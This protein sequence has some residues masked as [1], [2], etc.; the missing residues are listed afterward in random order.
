[1][2][3]LHASG[4]PPSAV[5]P[6]GF[7]LDALLAPIPGDLPAGRDLRRDVSGVS[8][9]A[10]LRDA[11][12]EARAAEREAD[13]LDPGAVTPLPSWR[14]I[15]R[16]AIEGLAGHSKDLEFAAALTEA[17]VRLQGLPGLA[18]GATL[19]RGLCEGFWDA[20]HPMPDE[21]GMATRF[22]PVSGL[23]GADRD[24]TL[25]QPL[26]RIALLTRPDGAPFGWWQYEQS[27][28]LARITDEDRRARRIASGVMPYEEIETLARGAAAELRRFGAEAAAAEAAWTAMARSLAE[29][30][31]PDPG[32]STGRV[33][34]LLGLMADVAAQLGPA[35]AGPVAADA[36]AP[37]APAAAMPS[38]APVPTPELAVPEDRE[39]MLRQL[40]TIAD[41]FR[42]TEPTSPL[43]YTLE[44]AVRRARMSWPELL[45][46]VVADERARGEILT[47]LGIRPPQA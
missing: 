15:L 26:R 14:G 30:A 2:P 44:E 24:G 8:P 4:S 45:A 43:S 19:I 29:L 3:D 5:L 39:A 13:S 23:S 6:E 36:T 21:E 9:L 20:L 17:A 46:E 38:L 37:Q 32:P 16:I 40:S 31:R 33:A 1:M 7:D 27:R 28:D 41:F 42:R 11:V 47:A 25:L 12:R 34:E 10:R 35:P 22:V 18:A